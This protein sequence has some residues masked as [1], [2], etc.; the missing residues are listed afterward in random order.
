MREEQRGGSTLLKSSS[1]PKRKKKKKKDRG[2]EN[3]SFLFLLSCTC[4]LLLGSPTRQ[5][6]SNQKN[7]FT[8][9]HANRE[10]ATTREREKT[11]GSYYANSS[12]PSHRCSLLLLI[13][14]VCTPH[15]R[16]HTHTSPR[17]PESIHLYTMWPYYSLLMNSPIAESI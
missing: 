9:T 8:P 17:K 14:D 5:Y 16:F 2:R 7:A 15:T 4:P 13:N 12:H 6:P 11:T 10:R 1:S 3:N